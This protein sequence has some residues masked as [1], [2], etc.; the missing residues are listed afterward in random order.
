MEVRNTAGTAISSMRI[1]IKLKK[2]T[3]TDGRRRAASIAT[4]R[5]PLIRPSSRTV[6]YPPVYTRR[7][8]VWAPC[9]TGH[10]LAFM[11]K[12]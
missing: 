3:V 4:R 8:A 7:T 12:P 6:P 11:F 1:T 10:L 5:A 9:L 2:T